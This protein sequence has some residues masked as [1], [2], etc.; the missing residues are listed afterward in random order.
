LQVT[1][2]GSDFECII[3]GAAA[4]E[5]IAVLAGVLKREVFDV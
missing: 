3:E 5:A 4:P 2:K 1:L